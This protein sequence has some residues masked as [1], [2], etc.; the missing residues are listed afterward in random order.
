[1]IVITGIRDIHI[2]SIQE[3]GGNSLAKNL[4]HVYHFYLFGER[5]RSGNMKLPSLGNSRIPVSVQSFPF[6]WI[7]PLKLRRTAGGKNSV[8]TRFTISCTRTVWSV[9]HGLFPLKLR[10]DGLNQNRCCQSI[11]V[12]R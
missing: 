4:A 7:C 10:F 3:D 5:G 12:R 2:E 6:I 9:E 8:K 1:M 11:F